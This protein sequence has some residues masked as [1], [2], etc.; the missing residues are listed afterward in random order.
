MADMTL[1]EACEKAKRLFEPYPYSVWELDGLFYVGRFLDT[2]WGT[3]HIGRRVKL[4]PYH[5]REEIFG[6]GESLREAFRFT[7][8]ARVYSMPGITVGPKGARG[9]TAVRNKYGDII[10]WRTP[11]GVFTREFPGVIQRKALVFS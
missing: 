8:G 4:A 11:G 7:D 5:R 3:D 1:H 6:V 2:G 10:G 9:M